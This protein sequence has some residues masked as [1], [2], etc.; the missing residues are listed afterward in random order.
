[1][2]SP[3]LLGTG[4]DADVVL[5]S[6]VRLARNIA[7]FPFS[8]RA[9]DIDRIQMLDIVR[10]RLTSPKVVEQLAGAMRVEH[11]PTAPAGKVAAT[12]GESINAG[13]APNPQPLGPVGSELR[14]VDLH[15]T[16]ELTRTV[17]VERQLIS[18]AH[19][20]GRPSGPGTVA[21]PALSRAVA[22]SL[23]DER[24]SIMVGEEDHLRIQVIGPGL[25]LPHVAQMSDRVDDAIE[26][27]LEYAFHPRFGYLTACPT[28][29]GTGIRHSVLLHLPA[30][31]LTGEIDMVKRSAED[32]GLAVRGFFGEGS[33]STGN[34]YQISNQQT[35]GQSEAM[36]QATIVRDIVPSIVEYE[37][38]ARTILKA[39]RSIT[40]ED[41][42][43]RAF[44][45][46]S[47]ARLLSVTEAMKLL[48]LLRLGVA[49]GMTPAN[50]TYADVHGLILM[51]QPGHLQRLVGRELDQQQRR[52]ERARVCRERL[53]SARFARLPLGHN[54]TD[55]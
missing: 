18:K 43:H 45:A 3:W 33:E 11:T 48:S 12:T 1:M 35:L 8:H 41:A 42:V 13:P 31:Q 38:R 34:F 50:L 16:D 26:Q 39:R 4:Q 36:L 37:R 46:L 10:A 28:N 51:S 27:G 2:G 7:G 5:S 32:M 19:A 22:V 40:T 52:I 14:W 44:G 9:T 54:R 20:Q 53:G 49:L 17:L 24:L 23:P 6:R 21:D 55:C 47:C 15:T 30:L 25:S 29:V